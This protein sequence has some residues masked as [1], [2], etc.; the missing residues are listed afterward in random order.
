MDWWWSFQ[1]FFLRKIQV[2]PFW[3]CLLRADTLL[4]VRFLP[5]KWNR[6]FWTL[7]SSI[8]LWP[9]WLKLFF[10]DWEKTFSTPCKWYRSF[11]VPGL[12]CVHCRELMERRGFMLMSRFM[13]LI[14][15]QNP[16]W[17][18]HFSTVIVREGHRSLWV[19]FIWTR[20]WFLFFVWSFLVFPCKSFCGCQL[21]LT[22][23]W[24]R[25]VFWS[26]LGKVGY[27]DEFWC[28]KSWQQWH[29][30]PYVNRTWRRRSWTGRI[31]RP[32]RSET[33]PR[34]SYRSWRCLWPYGLYY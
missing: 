29:Q 25:L 34:T 4:K 11:V 13:L 21:V 32:N 30:S 22:R 1:T 17:E 5:D 24:L 7:C 15:I 3:C 12:L 33:V 16:W 9:G 6:W 31:L 26:F 10:I 8:L 28:N 20:G 23:G 14:C 27:F 2:F 18:N 19:K